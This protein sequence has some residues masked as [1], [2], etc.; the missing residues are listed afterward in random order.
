MYNLYKLQYQNN[1]DAQQFWNTTVCYVLI[2]G[3]NDEYLEGK[4]SDDR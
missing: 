1:A 3:W 4:L 2:I